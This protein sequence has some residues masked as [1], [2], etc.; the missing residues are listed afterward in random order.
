MY[1]TESWVSGYIEKYGNK[2]KALGFYHYT[3]EIIDNN[4]LDIC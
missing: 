4:G 1:S 2:S 3:H